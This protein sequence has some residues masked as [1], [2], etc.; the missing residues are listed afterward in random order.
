MK[1]KLYLIL[2]LFTTINCLSQENL[3]D[4]YYP[5]SD[6]TETKVYKYVDKQDST[7]IE[8][9]KV[10]YLPDRN[11]L[12]TIS[13]DSEFNVYNRF[14]EKIT[15]NSAELIGYYD[16]ETTESGRLIEIKA[17]VIDKDVYKW[18]DEKEYSY[19]VKYANKYGRFDF[20]KKREEN[21][22]KKVK[23]NGKEYLTAKFKDNYIIFAIDHDTEHRFHQE[24]YYAKNIGMV[25]YRREIPLEHKIIELELSEI[26]SEKEFDRIK[27]NR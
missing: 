6:K 9:W 21:G 20:K 4:F 18:N 12:H 27:A 10:I 14:Y 24:T 16:F 26:L 11:E 5:M 3:K 17:K 23:V 15:E 7:N 19:S 8:Y 22:I 2:I 13:Y 1:N 25:K